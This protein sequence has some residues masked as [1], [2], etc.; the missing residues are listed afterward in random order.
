MRV[1]EW[2]RGSYAAKLLITFGL[3]A[4]LV[5]GFAVAVAGS[6][7][8]LAE[9]RAEAQLTDDA[10]RQAAALEQW[11]DGVEQRAAQLASAPAVTAGD[12]AGIDDRLSTLSD[13]LGSG[14]VAVHY[15]ADGS[16]AASTAENPSLSQTPLTATTGDTATYTEPYKS[17]SVA[18]QTVAYVHPTTEGALVYSL[19]PSAVVEG[20]AASAG[21]GDDSSEKTF[22]IGQSQT[23]VTATGSDAGGLT[24]PSLDGSVT[25]AT[26]DDSG[27]VQTEAFAV[28]SDTT[29]S[30]DDS[31]ALVAYAGVAGT[32]WTL[33]VQTDTATAF[34]V[35]DYATSAITGVALIA[36]VSLVLFGSTVGSTTVIQTRD[37]QNRANRVADGELDL[38]F[39]TRR[40]DEFGDVRQSM[41]RMR[42]TLTTEIEAAEQAE[43]EAE[44]ARTE[45]EDLS[46]TVTERAESYAT[47][48]EAAADGDLTRRVPT[49][50]TDETADGVEAMNRIGFAVND[51][52]A[53]Y[54][55]TIRDLSAFA[56]DVTTAAD[57]V[58]VAADE[59]NAVSSQIVERLSQIE[60]DSTTQ[61]EEVSALAAE[62]DQLSATAEEIAA[63]TSEV[64]SASETAVDAAQDGSD[65]AETAIDEM[66]ETV[67]TIAETVDA[68]NALADRVDQVTEVV[69]LISDVADETDMLAVNASIEA[70][71]AGGDGNGVD[72]DGF[73]VVAEEVKALAEEAKDS[74]DEVNEQLEAI[75]EQTDAAVET[76]D[77]AD[78]TLE[79]AAITVEDALTQLGDISEFAERTNDSVTEISRATSD[80]AESTQ[81]ASEVVDDVEAISEQTAKDANSLVDAADEQAGVIET[82]AETAETLIEDAERLQ[83]SLDEL[84]IDDGGVADETVSRPAATDD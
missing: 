58:S 79:E 35:G 68:I 34:A 47:E 55:E 19:D 60:T 20:T 15:V 6:T 8:S 74:A 5:S 67:Q 31:D 78:E 82:V 24:F 77:D 17:D 13:T 65:A 10:D 28:G 32:P 2:V 49:S 4:A 11:S 71:R 22:L 33:A 63:T 25:A 61:R 66:E 83:A 59:A 84:T 37:L 45:A 42:Q 53:A 30:A 40:K 29:V 7:T 12:T 44:V 9:D 73:A 41:D 43:R 18:G 39:P 81:A 48:L 3:I 72:G 54:E 26:G 1:T 75:R 51:L 21:N 76:A 57:D 36:L 38:G 70:A 52:V 14:V 16:V 50:G 46:A 80:Q 23:V 27:V 56:E 69:D 62:I 64:E